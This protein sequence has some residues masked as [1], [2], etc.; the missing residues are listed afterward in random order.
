MWEP[1]EYALTVEVGTQHGFGRTDVAAGGSY[2]HHFTSDTT[3]TVGVAAGK[4][5]FYPELL[6]G[7]SLAHPLFGLDASGG[8]VR[9]QWK[10]GGYSN[11]VTA[12][13]NR[14]FD[15]WIVGGYLRY[16][17]GEP[18]RFRSVGG[19]VGVSYYVWR[20]YTI[21]VGFDVGDELYREALYG[22][23]PRGFNVGGSRWLD[24]SSGINARFDHGWNT[25]AGR[26]TGISVS[27]FKEW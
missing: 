1:G 27:W 7:V 4:S 15:H 20:K 17:W 26:I 6:L 2:L 10:D 25:F 18:N 13:A 19:G 3:I 5:I 14:W 23:E 8:Y 11:E 24:E 9:R 22:L 12:G 16:H 21:G